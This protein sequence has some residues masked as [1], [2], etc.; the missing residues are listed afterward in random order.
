MA[1]EAFAIVL[2]LG[3]FVL[4][5]VIASRPKLDLV[6]YAIVATIVSCIATALAF[7]SPTPDFIKY[8]RFE[9][10]I[11]IVSINIIVII[12]EKNSVFQF[13]AVETI[14]LTK[15]NPRV[16]FA[17]ICIISTFTS[18]VME[19]V[20]VAL[21][22]MPIVIQA[23]KL[24]N[25]KPAPFIFGIAVCLNI[26]NL[27][28]PFSNSQ[29]IIIAAD[30]GLDVPWFAGFMFPILLLAML[31]VIVYIDFFEIRKQEPPAEEFKDILLKVLQPTLVVA[32][33]K[34]FHTAVIFFVCIIV[35][36]VLFPF[37][38]IVAL[39]GALVLCYLERE[40]LSAIFKKVDW[41]T[42][43][44]F[45]TLFLITGCMDIN[46]TMGAVSGLIMQVTTGNPFIASIAILIITSLVASVLSPNP[47]TVFFLPVFKTLFSMVPSIGAT[48]AT[49]T[50]SLIAFL[51]GLNIGGN[52]L[53]QGAPPYVVTL[54]IAQ[55][56]KIDDI[57]F[58]SMT[59]VGIKFSILH[60]LLSIGYLA[61]VCMALGVA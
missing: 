17:F 28:M 47:A 37:T 20:S 48:L 41:G 31:V 54:G 26:G 33:N 45:V 53:P 49:Q 58:K 39:L 9:P 60:M 25:I 1:G 59:L 7:P 32:N 57:N 10:L 22:F 44:F 13:I 43:F 18:A 30:F 61:L 12:L 50:P 51:L 14:H 36:L 3:I 23:C 34:K 38:Y 2:V 16:F 21:I 46:G 15:S 35:C 19:D 24:L 55:K 11:Y 5:P 6:S 27:F 42:A 4:I 29:N 8:I 40:S 56:N 52:F